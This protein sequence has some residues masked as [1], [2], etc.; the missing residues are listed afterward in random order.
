MDYNKNCKIDFGKYCEVHDELGPT[1][2]TKKITHG[3]IAMGPT[4]NLSC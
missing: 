2:N 4:G 1:N 3:A